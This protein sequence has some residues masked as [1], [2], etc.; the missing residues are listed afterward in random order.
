ML[1]FVAQE[2]GRGDEWRRVLQAYNGPMDPPIPPD[3]NGELW[4]PRVARVDG[5][6]PAQLSR[7]HGTLIALGCLKFELSGKVGVQ[8]QLTA[9]GRQTLERGL[10]TNVETDS[11]A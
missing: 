9:V 7:L 1:D 3:E 4:R 8:Y 5:V 2:L 11:A 10:V 6:E